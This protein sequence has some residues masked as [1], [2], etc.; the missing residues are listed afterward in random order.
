MPRIACAVVCALALLS[1]SPV[2]ANDDRDGARL[3]FANVLSARPAEAAFD[4]DS[5][6][7]KRVDL[8]LRLRTAIVDQPRWLAERT[9][10]AASS[11]RLFT[12]LRRPPTTNKEAAEPRRVASALGIR[13]NSFPNRKVAL[14]GAVR[15]GLFLK[16][17]LGVDH[18]L[19]RGGIGRP[20]PSVG[21]QFE[22][23]FR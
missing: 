7:A 3:Y 6:L 23:T 16:V 21:L 9:E 1:G 13:E 10:E 2:L 18:E 14:Q 19:E 15:D 11:L 17:S 20:T 8:D 12:S 5:I 22:R 4:N